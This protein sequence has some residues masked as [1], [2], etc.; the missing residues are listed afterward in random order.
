MYK[1]L[2]GHFLLTVLLEYRPVKDRHASATNREPASA[3]WDDSDNNEGFYG[4]VQ[5]TLCEAGK[6]YRI[7]ALLC[8]F[9]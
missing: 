8:G 4:I 3:S 2:T 9:G 1:K 6:L 7:M 5:L